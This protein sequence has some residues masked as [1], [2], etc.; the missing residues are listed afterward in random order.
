MWTLSVAGADS[1][2]YFWTARDVNPV[3]VDNCLLSMALRRVHFGGLNATWWRH[4]I[5]ADFEVMVYAFLDWF[6][7]FLASVVGIVVLEDFNCKIHNR[8][9]GSL[10]PLHTSFH[11]NRHYIYFHHTVL[12]NRSY[13]RR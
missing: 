5:N 3:H 9:Y 13:I 6:V 10:P 1:G 11:Y 7:V 2:R 12:C 8:V 4:L